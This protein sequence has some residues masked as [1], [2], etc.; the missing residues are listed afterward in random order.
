MRIAYSR[1]VN[2]PEFRELAPFLYYDFVN[3]SI[4][5][6]NPNLD[7]A[8][9]HN[10]DL[11]Y[12][13]YPRPGETISLAAFYKNFN[14][15]IEYQL[16]I[17]S[18]G[19]QPVSFINADVANNLGL[20]LEVRKSLSDIA[21]SSFLR[22]L[23]LSLNASVIRSRV[24]LGAQATAQDR[25][26]PL[27]GQSPYVVNLAAFYDDIERGFAV[28]MFYN[29]FGARIFR[30]GSVTFPTVYEMPRNT[31][32]LTVSK[33]IGPRLT[34]KAGAQNILNARFLFQQDSNRDTR[35]NGT[36]ETVTDFRRGQYFT[37]GVGVNL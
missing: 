5:F 21:A 4:I 19:Q 37:L 34:L 11:R 22:N 6:G 2:R 26:R 30:V 36:D 24:D 33:T 15:P 25:V 29:V 17:A 13:F 12:E 31:L 35:I 32:D 16:Q 20:E 28:N 23:S 7:I 27:Q 14:N 1:T 3:E 9:I 8:R 10:V 18:D